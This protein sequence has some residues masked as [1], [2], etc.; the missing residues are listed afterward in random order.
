M[1]GKVFAGAI[2]A[3]QIMGGLNG[4]KDA[5]EACESA[6]THGTDFKSEFGKITGTATPAQDRM[7]TWGAFGYFSGVEI[8]RRL[9]DPGQPS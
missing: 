2:V 6:Q 5:L 8:G 7:N 1:I 4:A 3:V 9:A